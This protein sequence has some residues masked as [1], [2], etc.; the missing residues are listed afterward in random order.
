M[1]PRH[2]LEG[3]DVFLERR[4]LQFDGIVVGGAALNL[5]GV[6]SRATKDCDVLDPDIPPEIGAAARAFAEDRRRAGDVLQDNWFNNGPRSLTRNLPPEWREHVQPLFE[7]KSLRLRTLGREDTLRAK[8]FALCD[9]GLDL[10]D[11]IALA[12][13]SAELLLIR[14]WL[15][16]QDG[17]PQWPAHVVATLADLATRLGHAV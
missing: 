15:E 3:F 10:G 2:T 7:G 1:D 4:G 6:I 12:P 16:Q 9:R 11:C 13:T 17:N 14:P 8:L 5:M